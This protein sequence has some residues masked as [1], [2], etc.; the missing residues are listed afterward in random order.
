MMTKMRENLHVVLWALVLLFILT[1]FL[2]WG[3]GGTEVFSDKH[4]AGKIGERKISLQQFENHYR[5]AAENYKRNAGAE[6]PEDQKDFF[7]EQVWSQLVNEYVLSKELDRH[8]IALTDSEFVYGTY[9]DPIPQFK[10]HP[11]FLENGVFEP[12]KLRDF[13]SKNPNLAG[14]LQYFYRST[15]PQKSMKLFL[16]KTIVVSEAEVR[17][18]YKKE[19]LKAKYEFVGINKF[20][21]NNKIFSTTDEELLAHYNKNKEDY[22]VEEKR[23][24]EYIRFDISPSKED[25]MIILE[26]LQDVKNRIADGADFGEE[27]RYSSEDKKSSENNGELEFFAK[28]THSETLENILFSASKDQIVGPVQDGNRFLLA[29]V[30]EKRKNKETKKEEI[31]I[32][33]IVKFVQVGSTTAQN[34]DYLAEEARNL[35]LEEGS[36]IK[37]YAEKNNAYYNK[38]VPFENKGFIPGIGR[39][40]QLNQFVFAKNKGSVSHQI[41]KN[42]GKS[43]LLARI[44]DIKSEGYDSFEEV[45][46]QVKTK[47]IAE[48]KTA[49][50]KKFALEIK[51]KIETEKLTDILAAD[52]TKAIMSGDQQLSQIYGT[53]LGRLG[54]SADISNT[55]L[56]IE[57]NKYSDVLE[58]SVGFF[59]VKVLERKEFDEKDY[60]ARK[61]GIR[62]NLES[63][64]LNSE[65][66]VWLTNITKNYD[67]EKYRLF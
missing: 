21:L 50:A 52:T 5:Q 40:L 17:E 62:E 55:V 13:I 27:A 8:G 65:F 35:A 31:K 9:A 29:K 11:D 30:L 3:A 63:Q 64:K 19:N 44:V 7:R 36:D 22:K 57:L 6:I 41:S 60:E 33:Q 66:N 37:A 15:F 61:A 47:V 54:K 46:N 28:G 34:F 42:K 38:T 43:I 12:K 51:S 59:M 25:T 58:S 53:H 67:I 18:A 24:I 39:D 20:K 2:Q 48:K 49:V 10:S 14:E 16:D 1:I 26:E 4:L 23:Q 32:Q 56:N 45:K